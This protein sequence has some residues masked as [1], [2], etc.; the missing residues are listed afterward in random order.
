MRKPRLVPALALFA[1]VGWGVLAAEPADKDH[2]AKLVD[3]LGSGNFKQRDAATKEL[4]AIGEPALDALRQAEQ[5]GDGEK[6]RRAADLIQRI[7]RRSDTARITAPTMVELKLNDVPLTEAVAGL[8]KQARYEITLGG[9]PAKLSAVRVRLETGKTTFWEALDRLCSAAGLVES[10]GLPPKNTPDIYPE[11]YGTQRQTTVV[12]ETTVMLVPGTPKTVPTS[13][14]GAFRV[15]ATEPI[16]ERGTGEKE[17]T[18][19]LGVR[20]E[21]GLAF[22]GVVGFR[23]DRAV[24]D[25]GQKLVAVHAPT[26]EVDPNGDP[27]DIVRLPNGQAAFIRRNNA[28]QQ[29]IVPGVSSVATP[30]PS[31]I[32]LK[33]G[34]RPSAKLT[35]LSGIVSVRVLA[36][37]AELASVGNVLK[38]EGETVKGKAGVTLKIAELA[39]EEDGSVTVSADLRCTTDAIPVGPGIPTSY[40]RGPGQAMRV[41]ALG[42]VRNVV[43]QQND[44]SIPSDATSFVGLELHD[45]AGK[46]YRLHKVTTHNGNIVGDAQSHFV[47]LNF[48]PA[49]KG[50]GEPAALVFKASH[51]VTVDVP[52]TLK[53]VPVR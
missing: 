4:D 36:P 25:E 21:P 42:G 38:A 19:G 31:S 20:P 33:K 15:R 44:P 53:D 35:E 43:I 29:A 18:V 8:A 26:P 7:G 22:G 16:P 17:L 2:I 11:R 41:R 30:A 49:E 51:W 14:S 47:V 9:D 45:S 37:V 50:Q 27:V 46:P 48:G 13:Y 1:G 5:S 40:G 52:F 39:R 24:D 32:H 34:D 3:Q 6:R 23:I 12:P 10:D 28:I